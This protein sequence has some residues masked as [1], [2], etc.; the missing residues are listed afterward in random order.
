MANSSYA[1]QERQNISSLDT[2]TITNEI[3][4][5]SKNVK[6]K[7]LDI[8][9]NSDINNKI[10]LSD[11]SLGSEELTVVDDV[12]GNDINILEGGTN[13]KNNDV[14][15]ESIFV[16]LSMDSLTAAIQPFVV[17]QDAEFQFKVSNNGNS[18]APNNR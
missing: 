18:T 13:T 16:D 1:F 17:G 5:N 15:I 7:D 2:N 9:V 12:Y 14:S 11:I 4:L 10:T 6:V 3:N 8:N